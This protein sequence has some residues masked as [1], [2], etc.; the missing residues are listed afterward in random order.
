MFF[1][2]F[3]SGFIVFPLCHPS[4]FL[5][6]ARFSESCTRSHLPGFAIGKFKETL[7]TFQRDVKKHNPHHN[8]FSH[9]STIPHTLLMPETCHKLNV[10]STAPQ[11]FMAFA[12]KVCKYASSFEAHIPGFQ[13]VPSL[14][15]RFESDAQD[16]A[17]CPGASYKHCTQHH[18]TRACPAAC[19]S[20]RPS[21]FSFMSSLLS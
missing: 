7:L 13:T 21:L 6:C 15:S 9:A 1:N 4:S 2:V 16:R 8:V 5:D 20:R 14:N 10:F 18:A 17:S 19:L 12:C 11:W 3:H